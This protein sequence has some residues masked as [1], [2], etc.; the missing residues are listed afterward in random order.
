VGVARTFE[1]E[2]IDDLLARAEAGSGLQPGELAALAA[3]L[4]RE[5]AAGDLEVHVDSSIPAGAG[6]GS[7]AA[8]AVAVTAAC[9]RALGLS[10]ARD[11]VAA[12]ALRIE[13]HQHGT[14]SGVDVQAVLRG[15]VIWC[16]RSA[17][18]LLHE[19]IRPSAVSLSAFRL[20][21]TG[22]PAESTGAMISA[23]RSLRDRE[24][25]RF[26]EA[27]ARMSDAVLDGRAALEGPDP[28]ALLAPMRSAQSALESLEVVHR[29]VVG[30]V[31]AIERAGGAAKI[32]GAGGRDGAGSGLLLVVHPDPAWHERFEPPA[33]WVR[34]DAALGAPGLREE[35]AV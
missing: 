24:P 11:E 30:A 29:D 31:R 1:P 17:T 12:G 3:T 2:E 16:R 27:V 26:D 28:A 6:F 5:G 10:G 15:G 20:Y 19:E 9:R 21:D 7:S 35:V 8:L 23:V 13:R 14:P 25:R 4:A 32:S 22:A 33:G 34:H 18:G